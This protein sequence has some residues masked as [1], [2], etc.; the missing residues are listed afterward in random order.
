[1]GFNISGVREKIKNLPLDKQINNE[2]LLIL[3]F[4][5]V[6][7]G[8]NN[9]LLSFPF[10]YGLIFFFAAAFGFALFLVNWHKGWYVFTRTALVIFMYL[11]TI[12]SWL[13]NDGITGAAI[14]FI[15]AIMVYS[16]GIFGKTYWW[17]ALV[18]GL[19]FIS[20]VLLNFHFPETL[21][22]SYS[23][24]SERVFDMSTAYIIVLISVTLVLK[25]IFDNYN[26]ASKRIAEQ[27]S[28][29]EKLNSELR[30]VNRRLNENNVLRDK[31]ISIIS[32]DLKSPV[33]SV[34]EMAGL[35]EANLKDFDKQAIENSVRVIG[36]TQRK[37]AEMLDDLLLWAR[38]QTGSFAFEIRPISLA[39]NCREIIEERMGQAIIKDISVEC[40][41]DGEL[42]V[43]A[44]PNMLK[45]ILRNLLSNAIKFTG[46]GGSVKISAEKKDGYAVV[47][48]TDKGTGISPER[49]ADILA[50]KS[51]YSTEGTK[52]ESGTGMGLLLCR[53]FTEFLG[54]ELSARSEPGKGSSFSF[55]VP[56]A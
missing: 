1:M 23:S 29:L 10:W 15:S 31:L 42:S 9:M 24:E 48:V 19:V 32:H 40:S 39:A 27:N 8:V 4:L 37:T 43:L 46:D 14:L 49:L 51:T 47:S 25:T 50:V 16:A 6:V 20:L 33:Q 3:S 18:N 36:K 45:T 34:A 11:I 12:A 28:E 41:V 30:V 21:K 13:F 7:T 53:E 26:R 54:G 52:G 56:L 38:S 5:S 2:V 44:D 35:I 55:T 17:L 22:Y